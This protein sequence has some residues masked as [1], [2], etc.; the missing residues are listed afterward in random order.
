MEWKDAV[1]KHCVNARMISILP[2]VPADE[3]TRH[4]AH[5]LF[6]EQKT[7]FEA[8]GK[9]TL[10]QMQ[11][12]AQEH[13]VDNNEVEVLQEDWLH[14]YTFRSV[15]TSLQEKSSQNTSVHNRLGSIALKLVIG[16]VAES[17]LES[18]YLAENDLKEIHISKDLHNAS[19]ATSKMQDLLATLEANAA[20]LT[21]YA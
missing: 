20:D 21:K 4:E 6:S 10:T 1:A 13:S 5:S 3:D 9:I 11:T 14:A 7:F 18:V 15:E 19:A 2:Y 12:L 17:N 8:H 16:R